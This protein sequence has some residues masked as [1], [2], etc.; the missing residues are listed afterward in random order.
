[1]RRCLT[2]LGWVIV[3][4]GTLAVSRWLGSGASIQ[5]EDRK[6]EAI[7]EATLKDS[8]DNPD[9]TQFRNTMAYEGD[10]ASE[11]WVCGWFIAKNGDSKDVGLRRF[12]V[13]VI[14]GGRHDRGDTSSSKSELVM[15]DSNV[16]NPA[17]FIWE[18]HCL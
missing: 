5:D 9:G 17:S 18:S 4:S 2:V 15:K 14:L 3:V 16:P 6:V 11:W 8:L 10:S 1:M 7:A 12:V 13:H